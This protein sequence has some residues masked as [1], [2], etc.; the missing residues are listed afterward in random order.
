MAGNWACL[1]PLEYWEEFSASSVTLKY[2][3]WR[4]HSISIGEKQVDVETNQNVLSCSSFHDHPYVS[5]QEE[6]Q[7]ERSGWWRDE[8]NAVDTLTDK[9]QTLHTFFSAQKQEPSLIISLF[10]KQ[11]LTLYIL[12]KGFII[13][14]HII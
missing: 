3:A 8:S 5:N 14:H 4:F 12:A 11:T 1:E 6:G 2:N 7:E 13:S 9:L 10:C